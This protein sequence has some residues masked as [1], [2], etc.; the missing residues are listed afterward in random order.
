MKPPLATLLALLLVLAGA[1]R[2]APRLVTKPWHVSAG[3]HAEAYSSTA[4]PEVD[5]SV[6]E[7]LHPGMRAAQACALLGDL[8]S[9]HHPV[10]A[11]AF[12][13]NP[14]DGER[15]EVALELSPDK[16]M[17]VDLSFKRVVRP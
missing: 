10:N 16:C 1:C 17:I 14:A 3:W 13:L 12:A 11:I 15:Y 8:Q 6:I 9:Y 5:W 4:Y 2:S 7:K